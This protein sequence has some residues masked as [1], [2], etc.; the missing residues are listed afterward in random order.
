MTPPLEPATCPLVSRTTGRRLLSI[1]SACDARQPRVLV[2]L[3]VRRE[4]PPP[5]GL[6][7]GEELVQRL[8]A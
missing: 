8:L 5:L 2:R 1:S 7:P 4:Q 3:R 6:D